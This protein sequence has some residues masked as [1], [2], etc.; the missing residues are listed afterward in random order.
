MPDLDELTQRLERARAGLARGVRRTVERQ[1]E[2]LRLD[3]ERLRRAPLLLVERRRAG[4]ERAAARLRALSPRAT[5]GRGYAIVRK[6]G[7]LVRA[8][9]AVAAGDR[10]DVEVAEG[11]FAARVEP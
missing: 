6:D 2:R 9:A 10:V 7:A 8:A 4:I 5:L 11:T 1:R 3:G